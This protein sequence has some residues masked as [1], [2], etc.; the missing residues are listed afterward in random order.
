MPKIDAKICRKCGRP[1]DKKL[2]KLDP[3]V[4]DGF[5]SWCR[6]CFNTYQ[7]ERA[8]VARRDPLKKKAIRAYVK[9][10]Q[11]AFLK[12]HPNYQWERSLMK[13]YGFTPDDYY[14]ELKRFG[15]VCSWCMS[16][17][18]GEHHLTGK[19][20]RLSV[21]CKVNYDAY[22]KPEAMIIGFACRKCRYRGAVRRCVSVAEDNVLVERRSP[23]RSVGAKAKPGDWL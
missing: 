8:K 2:F 22:G 10:Y 1:K 15:G 5:S 13:R 23:R 12:K 11:K 6:E 20:I 7:N 3:R 4:K 16:E 14:N 19:T 18:T 21:V 9:K 17:E